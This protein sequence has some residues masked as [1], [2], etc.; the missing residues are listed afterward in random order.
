MRSS[1][2]QTTVPTCACCAT[3]LLGGQVGQTDLV[4]VA[5][6]PARIAAA[7]TRLGAAVGAEVDVSSVGDGHLYAITAQGF[8]LEVVVDLSN[9]IGVKLGVADGG[10]YWL[11]WSTDTDLYDT[12]A[13]GGEIA[14][15]IEQ[16]VDAII[17]GQA[18]VARIKRQVV[19]FPTTE[20]YVV[21]RQGRFGTSSSRIVADE[22]ELADSTPLLAWAG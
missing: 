20:G 9:W 4:E 13:F 19:A 1:V 16:L 5:E 21:A 15:D 7:M 22:P 17:S 11:A 14:E 3:A 10:R 12:G 18:R 8:A 6:A 2:T